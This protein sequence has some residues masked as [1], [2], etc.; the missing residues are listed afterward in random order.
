MFYAQYK[1]FCDLVSGKC[2]CNPLHQDVWRCIPLV[3]GDH[4]QCFL[5]APALTKNCG[6]ETQ[7]GYEAG[8]LKGKWKI[9]GNSPSIVVLY[10]GFFEGNGKGLKYKGFLAKGN[11]I[12]RDN[13]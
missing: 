5:A 9:C 13:V 7:C 8:R 1:C 10:L 3:G 6:K 12:S 11:E 4:L 2:M